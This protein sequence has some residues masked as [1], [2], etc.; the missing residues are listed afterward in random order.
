M[1]RV[2]N[3]ISQECPKT[4]VSRDSER[5][6]GNLGSWLRYKNH[7]VVHNHLFSIPG[8]YII[9]SISKMLIFPFNLSL[10]S[11]L[12]DAVRGYHIH[13]SCTG[14]GNFI[15]S[16]LCSTRFLTLSDRLMMQASIGEAFN[17]A[18]QAVNALNRRDERIDRLISLLFVQPGHEIDDEI[19][20]PLMETFSGILEA[21]NEHN[22]PWFLETEIVFFCDDLKR[23][24]K[25]PMKDKKPG[26]NQVW[27][28]TGTEF[29][30]NM[31]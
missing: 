27:D 22:N 6:N 30:E 20:M 8:M 18:S 13:E 19:T 28:D 3:L 15:T 1:Q 17:M 7:E 14:T 2:E 10:L 16:P 9:E 26:Q 31:F 5:Y 11:V 4:L 29:P 21:R 12:V 24:K 25:R 23:M